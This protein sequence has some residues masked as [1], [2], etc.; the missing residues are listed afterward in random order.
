M[1]QKQSWMMQSESLLFFAFLSIPLSL[2]AYIFNQELERERFAAKCTM[3]QKKNTEMSKKISEL[4]EV[5]SLNLQAQGHAQ[6]NRIFDSYK[7]QCKMKF[8]LAQAL[9]GVGTSENHPF[10]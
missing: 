6:Y 4:E 1:E 10:L 7:W 5:I 3:L 2:F 9:A 8:G